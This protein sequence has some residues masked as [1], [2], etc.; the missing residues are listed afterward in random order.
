MVLDHAIRRCVSVASDPVALAF[1]RQQV[2]ATT[3][4]EWRWKR[5]GF[6]LREEEIPDVCPAHFLKRISGGQLAG[7]VEAHDAPFRIEHDDQRADRV[8]NCGNDI[9]FLLQ[10]LFGVLEIGDIEGHAVNEPRL[11]VGLAHHLRVAMEPD[12]AARRAP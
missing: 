5:V 12:H 1:L 7:A 4:Q 11:A 6:F 2:A 10:R 3:A 8:E 9:A